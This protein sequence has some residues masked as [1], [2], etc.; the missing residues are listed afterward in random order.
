MARA[1]RILVV[2]DFAPW[3]NQVHSL[4]KSSPGWNIIGEASDGQEAIEKAILM[5]PDII[6]LDIGMPVL[7]G[8]EAARIIHQRCPKAKIL[9]VTQ[10]SDADFRKAAMRAGAAGYVV[11]EN[12]AHDLSDAIATALYF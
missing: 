10:D 5:Q 3:R 7:N 4:L 6:L 1:A 11:K 9:F 2:D 8:I 12:A